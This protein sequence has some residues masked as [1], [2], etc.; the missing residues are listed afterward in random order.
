MI[1]L[2]D[3]T[4]QPLQRNGELVLYR[5]VR[6]D[7][8]SNT[9]PR[10]LVLAPAPAYA[11]PATLARLEREYSLAAELDRRWAARPIALGPHQGRTV[12]ALEDPGGAPLSRL[13]GKPMELG[14][15]LHLAIGLARAVAG[16]HA[17]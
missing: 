14:A 2:S 12:L 13:L 6:V 11:S 7:S 15:F 16:V 1:D 8:A 4:L 5:A 9:S 17:A 10:L 3:C